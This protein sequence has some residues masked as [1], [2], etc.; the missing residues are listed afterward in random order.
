M[1]LLTRPESVTDGLNA[2]CGNLYRGEHAGRAEEGE[3]ARACRFFPPQEWS[4]A[5]ISGVKQ[6]DPMLHRI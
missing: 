5:R 6:Q 2:A 4:A 3:A 1:Q